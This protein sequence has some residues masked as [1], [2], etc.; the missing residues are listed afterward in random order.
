MCMHMFAGY[1]VVRLE[2]EKKSRWA[3]YNAALVS[4]S[5]SP[6]WTNE[7]FHVNSF[8]CGFEGSG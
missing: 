6:A 2:V 8:R 5:L 7:N 4:R 3:R 1:F